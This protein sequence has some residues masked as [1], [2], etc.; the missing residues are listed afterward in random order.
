MRN[1]SKRLIRWK[2]NRRRGCIWGRFWLGRSHKRRIK[3]E[4]LHY[5]STRVVSLLRSLGV[6]WTYETVDAFAQLQREACDRPPGVRD[7]TKAIFDWL[8]RRRS[9]RTGSLILEDQTVVYL[10]LK[11]ECVNGVDSKLEHGWRK[12]LIA[13]WTSEHRRTW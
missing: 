4:E 3:V 11:R 1:G 2:L 13:G 10:M 8:H 7:T 6:I 5:G 9:T 12:K